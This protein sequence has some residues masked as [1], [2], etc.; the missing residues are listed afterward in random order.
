[1]RSTYAALALLVLCSCGEPPVGPSG[2]IDLAA[3]WQRASP[4]SVGLDRGRLDAAVRQARSLPQLQSL[5]VVRH[6]RLAL[7]EYFNGNH[8]DRLNDVRSVTK[9]VISTLVG[10]AVAR[11]DLPG[12]DVPIG[13]YLSA[14]Y[15]DELSGAE[16]AIT[17]RDLLTMSSGYAWDESGTAAYNAWINADDPVRYLLRR[18]L[19]DPPG[20]RFVYNSAAVHLLSVALARA[21]GQSL[22]QYAAAHLFAPL[23]IPGATWETFSDGTANG[24]SGIDLRPR[25]LAKLGALWLQR[26]DPGTGPLLPAGWVDTGTSS[27]FPLRPAT[28]PLS[29]QGYGYLWWVDQADGRSHFFAWGYG[30]QF[31]WVAPELDMVVVVTTDWRSATVTAGQAASNG[32]R[33]IIDNVLPAAR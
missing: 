29:Q 9:S 4:Q 6:G 15:G 16:A 17:I 20:T 33:L 22:Q 28:A 31:V 13:D 19:A 2:P 26:G 27:R 25:D 14:E 7:E 32:L 5:L 1:M 11:G 12:V 3:E 23:G 30:G 8:A 18:P 24:G 10:I 21:T